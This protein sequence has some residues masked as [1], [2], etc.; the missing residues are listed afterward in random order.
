LEA[1]NKYG[2]QRSDI[3][4]LPGSAEAAAWQ[5][6]GLLTEIVALKARQQA[7]TLPE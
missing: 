5:F 1:F 2:L 3:P 7:V 6:S 4:V